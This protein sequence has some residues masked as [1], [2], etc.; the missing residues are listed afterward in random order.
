MPSVHVRAS[1][2]VSLC[3]AIITGGTT[4]VQSRELP[5]YYVYNGQRV[6]L[7]L[8]L[9]RIAV[10]YRAGSTARDRSD[11]MTPHALSAATATPTGAGTWH[12]VPFS[13]A[14]P[15]ANDIAATL[16]DLTASDAAEFVSP[17]FNGPRETWIVPTQDILVGFKAEYVQNAEG[18]L[19]A[20]IPDGRITE[21]EFGR[22][23]GAF[24]IR[25]NARNGFDV[26]AEANR[27]AED[28]RVAW[29]EPDM[30]FS[31]W[32]SLIPNDF[33]FPSL[34]GI[35]NTGQF[36]GTPDMDMDC[37]LAWDIST[38]SASIKVVV[39]DVGVE[40]T[41]PDINQLPGA[42]FTGEGGGGGP[43]NAC[44]NHGTPVAGCVSAIINNTIGVVGSAPGCPVLSARPFIANLSCNGSWSSTA[45][46]TVD[47]LDWG[48]LQGARVSNN[49][50]YYGF[51]SGAI[52]S[53]YASTYTNGMVHFSSA[54]NDGA[55]S[56]SYPASLPTV[57]AI[58][59]L[60]PSGAKSSFSNFG[61][62]L[63]LSAP[64]SSVYSTDRTGLSG[65]VSGDYVV[66]AGTSFAS[67]YTAGVAALVLSVE[68]FLTTPEVE[69]KLRCSAMDLGTSGFDNTFGY[70]FVNANNAISTPWGGPCAFCP[71]IDSD[72]D[73]DLVSDSCDNC[74]AVANP[75]QED[76]DGDGIGNACDN[77]SS[78]ANAGQEDADG[79]SFGDACDLC[80]SVAIASNISLMT[81]DVNNDGSLTSADIIYMVN[82]VFKSGVAPVPV[83]EVGDV[84][85]SGSLTSADVIYL[86]NYVFKGGPAPCDVCTA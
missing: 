72:V 62:L 70:G 39:L 85:C 64:G 14:V 56:V 6:P 66:V 7:E 32:G 84:N 61:P 65:W 27:L 49:S 67:P 30:H 71:A 9:T 51:T 11:A 83:S 47:A 76:A 20:T 77:C 42:D 75:T 60:D 1:L 86:V 13:Q 2:C 40:Q 44:D 31:G 81:G 18:V 69:R 24:K 17:V 82:H 19:S 15:G 46:W 59:A 25:S 8:D 80:P 68:P 50:N 57:N 53:K 79:D 43:V 48:E 3:C 21:R 73:G 38:G 33:Y 22:M 5:S 54:G 12:L 45:S 26:L 37:E 35:M 41:H 52:A 74:Q 34:W 36:G 10:K 16:D 63:S 78:T 55:G 58:A 28:P 4:T 23:P 29:A